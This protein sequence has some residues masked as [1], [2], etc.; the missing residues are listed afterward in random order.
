MSSSLPNSAFLEDAARDPG[1][2]SPH[3]SS[4][5]RHRRLPHR[6]RF[7]PPQGSSGDIISQSPTRLQRRGS[8]Q[9]PSSS[10]F[11]SAAGENSS[12]SR[13]RGGSFRVQRTTAAAFD[14]HED[15]RFLPVPPVNILIAA[16]DEEED[17]GVHINPVTAASGD[18]MAVRRKSTSRLP[19]FHNDD[20]DDSQPDY[21][22]RYSPTS[23][24]APSGPPVPPE[25]WP[26]PNVS[27]SDHYAA[28]AATGTSRHSPFVPSTTSPHQEQQQHF[29]D[30]FDEFVYKSQ[31]IA[32]S[33]PEV[34][35]EVPSD[36]DSSRR[37]SKA[38]FGRPASHS[39]SYTNFCGSSAAGSVAGG[40]GS[41]GGSGGV[42]NSGGGSVNG[43]SPS[44]SPR[45]SEPPSVLAKLNQRRASGGLSAAANNSS[46]FLLAARPMLDRRSS[47]TGVL[48][49]RGTRTHT[50]GA[51][52]LSPRRDSGNTLGV[53]GRR[54]RGASLP[55]S[56]ELNTEDIY[57]LRNFS[58]AGRKV[59]N[60]GDSLK[61]RSTH[62]INSTGS[63]LVATRSYACTKHRTTSFPST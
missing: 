7:H 56:M 23:P 19:E 61:A 13:R 35:I 9:H 58:L 59:I 47:H 37:P 31:H 6:R 33:P 42:G 53:P 51:S 38:S 8:Y 30:Q 55:G 36:S 57:R 5:R 27:M 22:P 4:P 62:S 44:T 39:N 3:D 32:S 10:R 54:S 46:A 63:R 26:L 40:G 14:V 60:R 52:G 17:Q 41:G 18:K 1:S 49:S 48:L 2:A 50:P 29:D 45:P 15:D 43:P 25:L 21:S 11:G 20:E 28:P 12:D 24:W 34:N 16:E